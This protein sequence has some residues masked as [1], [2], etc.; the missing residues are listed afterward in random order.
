[1]P[2]ID[3]AQWPA[4]PYGAWK[5]TCRTLH[6][7]T[8]I[9]GKIRLARTPWLNHSWHVTLYVTA[10]GLTTWLIPDGARQFQIDFDFIDH[11]LWLRTSD[12]HYRQLVLRPMPV[13][14]FHVD[15]FHALAELGI[16]VRINDKPN[17]IADAIPFGEDLVHASYDGDYAQRFW[18]ILR[19]S[20]EAFSHFRTGFLGK[21]SPVHFFWGSFD[22]AVT[23][24]S[25]RPA[26]RHPGGVP[27]L[28]DAVA[29]EAYSHEVSSA[30]FWPG[31]GGPIE[32]PA[33]YSYAYP[34]PAG[35]ADARV[36]PAAAFF[37]KELGEFIL[38]YDAVRS[39]ENPRRALM[40]F[41]QSTYDAAA[42][43][44]AWDRKALECEIGKAR[45]PRRIA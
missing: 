17:E 25:G 19:L 24:F 44:G 26:P 40:E 23:R 29:Q 36:R 13:A 18:R 9:V 38:P 4:L 6:L 3:L 27:N 8:Q 33:Y 37:S 43:L 11:V 28:P 12:G 1:M 21:A 20:H 15:L 7:W 41:L 30:G 39:A 34:A 22:L 31:G 35:F 2:D 42:D 45:V 5:E 14:E 32:E 16:H 10:R